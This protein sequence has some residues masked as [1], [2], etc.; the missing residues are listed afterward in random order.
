MGEE[1][2][3]HF[4]NGAQETPPQRLPFR[5][6]PEREPQ[7]GLKIMPFGNSDSFGSGSCLCNVQNVSQKADFLTELSPGFFPVAGIS[8]TTRGQAGADLISQGNYPGLFHMRS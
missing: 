5:S 1:R 3:C 4:W 6:G 8:G 7:E 2:L